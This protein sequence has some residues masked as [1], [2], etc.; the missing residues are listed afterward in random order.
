M[1]TQ[2]KSRSILA[3]SK[4]RWAHDKIDKHRKQKDSNLKR[5]MLSTMNRACTP[6]TEVV[7]L[8]EKATLMLLNVNKY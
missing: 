7:G 3:P 4:C 2:K 6:M 5:P 8:V 1:E